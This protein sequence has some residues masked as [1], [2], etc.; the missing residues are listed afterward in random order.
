MLVLV[1]VVFVREE[2]EEEHVEVGVME[3][4]CPQE[5]KRRGWFGGMRA[6][7]EDDAAAESIA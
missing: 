5:M 2:R 3:T 6:I 1:V 7:V 4:V